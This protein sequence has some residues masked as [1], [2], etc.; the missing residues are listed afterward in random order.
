MQERQEYWLS[1]IGCRLSVVGYRLSVVGCRLS[2]VGFGYR[3]SV[4]GYRLSVSGWQLSCIARRR[5]QDEDRKLQIAIPKSQ[6]YLVSLC[7]TTS[8]RMIPAETDTFS[9][10]MAPVIGIE[11]C[12]SD[13]PSSSRLIPFSSEPSMTTR[14]PVS[15]A[16]LI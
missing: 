10:P 9:E 4:I 12:V 11:T 6:I 3:L 14:G 13:S 1:V 8:Y 5:S 7:L 16:A 2:V 15:V